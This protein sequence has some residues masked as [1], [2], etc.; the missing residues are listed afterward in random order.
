MLRLVIEY[1][2]QRRKFDL[3]DPINIGLLENE[4]KSRFNIDD[5][6]IIINI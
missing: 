3:I 4:I 5:P 1:G 6:E 2:R